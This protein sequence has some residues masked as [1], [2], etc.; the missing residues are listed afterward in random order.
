L[1]YPK[2][3]EGLYES[4]KL[5][6]R[7]DGPGDAVAWLAIV[8]SVALVCSVPAVGI[9]VAYV[10]WDDVKKAL[11]RNCWY[12]VWRTWRSLLLHSLC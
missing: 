11:H 1:F 4:G 10:C 9:S 2:A 3:V 5:L 6:H 12:V 7:A 8:L